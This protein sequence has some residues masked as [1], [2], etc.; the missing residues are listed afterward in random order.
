MATLRLRRI[1]I[2]VLL[3][4]LLAALVPAAST[5]AEEFVGMVIGTAD[6]D[7]ITVLHNRRPERI[8]L[9][10]IDAPEKGQPFGERARQFTARLPSG[11]EVTVRVTGR[12]RYGR[13]LAEVLL[14]DGR[15]LNQEL[16][17]AGYAWW[18]RRYANDVALEELE[19]QAR[20]THVGLWADPHPVPPWEWRNDRR[21]A[22]AVPAGR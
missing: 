16:V 20:L 15:S 10:G 9:S 4:V 14:P 17:R 13:F 5:A 22:R 6:G 12:D 8:R 21:A 7:T 1:Q 11:H 2:T 3:T 18:Y 19:A